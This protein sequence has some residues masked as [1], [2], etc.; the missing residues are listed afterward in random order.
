[1]KTLYLYTTEGCHLCEEAE[2]L[3]A[4]YL[5]RYG[6]VLEP[7][8][9]A[10]SSDLMDRY[11]TR[12][13]VLRLEDEHRELSWPFTSDIFIAFVENSETLQAKSH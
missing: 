1:M 10:G 11:G 5:V 9:I 8:D 13:P 6:L 3:V 4:P 7:V 2:R 12:I